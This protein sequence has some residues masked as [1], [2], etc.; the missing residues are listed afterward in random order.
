MSTKIPRFT[1]KTGRTWPLEVT[2]GT[3]RDLRRMLDVDLLSIIE[4]DSGLLNRLATDAVLLCDVLYV[5]CHRD[6]Q[7][8]GV[9][10]EDFGRSLGGE[11]IDGAI[12]AFLEAV[13][14]FFQNARQAV[15]S[16]TLTGN[17]RLARFV[18]EAMTIVGDRSLLRETLRS[19]FTETPESSESTPAATA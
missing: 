11:A 15:R 18:A 17:A 4:P 6:C 7:R 12:E 14:A 13:D 16:K 1:D 19:G 9:S 3:V 10:D 5:V 2:V 8:L